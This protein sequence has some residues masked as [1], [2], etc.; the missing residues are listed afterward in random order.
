MDNKANEDHALWGTVTLAL[1]HLTE[2]SIEGTEVSEK[3]TDL[4]EFLSE[5]NAQSQGKPVTL[6]INLL[7]SLG[8]GE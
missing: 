8:G 4:R 3:G 7:L 6:S 1:P 5:L 2:W